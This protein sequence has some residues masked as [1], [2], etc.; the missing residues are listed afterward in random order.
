MLVTANRF[1]SSSSYQVPYSS[2]QSPNAANTNDDGTARAQTSKVSTADIDLSALFE[3][4]E[5][6]MVA[7]SPEDNPC[8]ID[9]SILFEQFEGNMVAAKAE[10][11][12]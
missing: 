3:Q 7:D 9:L 5:E 10:S 4:F 12:C 2:Q 6:N 11:G 1:H 8:D